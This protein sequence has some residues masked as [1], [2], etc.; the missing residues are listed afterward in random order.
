MF[1]D[2]YINSSFDVKEL[3][4]IAEVTGARF[5]RAESTGV[6]WEN[7]NDIDRLEK[8][9][10]DIRTWHEFYDRSGGFLIAGLAIF[11]LEILLRSVIYRKVP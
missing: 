3:Q 5:Y 1:P 11:F 7:I 8:S 9:E 10:V 2:Q 4:K 6:F